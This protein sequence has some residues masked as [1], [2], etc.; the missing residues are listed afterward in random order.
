MIIPA[1]RATAA[2][3]MIKRMAQSGHRDERHVTIR[4]RN[5]GLMRS[6]HTRI[7][8]STVSEV[9]SASEQIV[10]A[11]AAWRA[12]SRSR[13]RIVRPRMLRVT[14]AHL[15][16]HGRIAAAPESRQV[17]RGLHRPMR[18]RQQ[19]DHQR[20][21]AAGDRRDGGR[22]RTAP[23]RGSRF[24][25][26]P[27]PRSR[28]ARC[29]PVGASKWVGASASS[30]ARSGHGS[31]RLSAASNSSAVSS[32]SAVFVE[33]RR[34][35]PFARRLCRARHRKGRATRRLRSRAGT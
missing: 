17:A 4:R 19:F 13:D 9:L 28:S 3:V 24:L 16:A 20:H 18:R 12:A 33:Q 8:T 14:S 35:Q 5:K 10:T 25:D 15:G 32:A 1:T 23:A 26:R 27:R 7:C 22:V 2:K 11:C 34:R 21:F 30:A 29:E 6:Q 31:E